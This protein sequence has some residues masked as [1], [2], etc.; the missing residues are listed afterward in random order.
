M[1]LL[2]IKLTSIKISRFERFCN[3]RHFER[4]FLNKSPL[5]NH[6]IKGKV[7]FKDKLLEKYFLVKNGF[8]L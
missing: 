6:N 2:E 4:I 7:T 8:K 3:A 5:H 1:I